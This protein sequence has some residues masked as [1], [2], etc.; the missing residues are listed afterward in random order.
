VDPRHSK[1]TQ[2]ALEVAAEYGFA[3]A[4]GYAVSAHG[5]GDRLSSDVD[6]FT[7]WHSRESFPRA[8]N[9]IIDAMQSHG[10]SVSV[11]ILNETFARLLLDDRAAPDQEAEKLE[12]SADWRAHPPVMSAVG[13]VLHPD[14]AVAN[15]MCALFGRAEARDF[16]DVD[17]A[18]RSGRYSRERLLELAAGS[19]PGF[20][21]VMFA[22]ALGSLRHITDADFDLYGSSPDELAAMRERF[23][24]WRASISRRSESPG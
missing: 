6:L 10:Y 13:P 8:V 4:G 7:D 23:A 16:L 21:P 24:D 3:L 1:I 18:I 9:A 11:V 5:M 22:D 12:L 14:D 19:D 2:I 15:K 17:A 20:D